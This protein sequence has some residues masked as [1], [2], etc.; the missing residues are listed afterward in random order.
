M[1]MGI[2]DLLST[3]FDAAQS[4]FGLVLPDALSLGI[5]ALLASFLSM[6][7]YGRLSN[8][9]ALNHIRP[10]QKTASKRLAVY[11]GPFNG[12]W[13]LVR[14]NFSLSAQQMWLTFFP[15][16]VATIPILFVLP[17]VSNTFGSHFPQAG[18]AIAVQVESYTPHE[19]HWDLREAPQ[20]SGIG[21]WT[22]SW[23]DEGK[24][25]HL[26]DQHEQPV[27]ALPLSEP[28]PVL[29]KRLWWNYLIGN[30]AGYLDPDHVVESITFN[31]PSRKFLPFGPD[32]L[33]GWLS[34]FMLY[35]VSFSLLLKWRWRLH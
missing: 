25:L 35:L 17:W 32:W 18:E 14:E 19:L 28:T 29:H 22:L 21:R 23:P 20:R 15:A 12:L 5:W 4:L 16:L 6:W 9:E 33:R 2:F 27:L 13:P 30:P 8:Q 31:F 24:E 10:L 7:T 26:L 3:V 1:D 11:D 34:L